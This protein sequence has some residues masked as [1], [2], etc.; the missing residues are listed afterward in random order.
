MPDLLQDFLSDDAVPALEI[1][2]VC[3][4]V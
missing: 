1:K 2:N 4:S 3:E